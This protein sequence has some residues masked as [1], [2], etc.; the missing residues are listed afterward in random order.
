[1]DATAPAPTP[2]PKWKQYIVLAVVCGIA[3]AAYSLLRGPKEC[4]TKDFH[5]RS[6]GHHCT[7]SGTIETFAPP[8]NRVGHWK[9]GDHEVERFNLTDAAGTAE[10]LVLEGTVKLPASGTRVVVE[11]EVTQVPSLQITRLVASAVEPAP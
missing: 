3:F 4:T 2:L 1:M 5:D 9:L 7:L 8:A 10:V 6:V 11:A